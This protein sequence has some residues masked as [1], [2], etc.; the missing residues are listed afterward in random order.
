MKTA[1]LI[2]LCLLMGCMGPRLYTHPSRGASELKRD[3]YECRIEAMR[4]AEG[5]MQIALQEECM[6]ARGWTA[7]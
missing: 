2:A 4:T 7:Q 1:I 5:F 6:Q 3:V